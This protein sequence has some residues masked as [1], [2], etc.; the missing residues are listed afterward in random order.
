M[1]K[2]TTSQNKKIA[3]IILFTYAQKTLQVS[4]TMTSKTIWKMCI[5]FINNLKRYIKMINKRKMSRKRRKNIK[6]K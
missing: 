4:Q 5:Q 1:Q 3:K 6:R 2:V